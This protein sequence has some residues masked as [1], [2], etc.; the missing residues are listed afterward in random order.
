MEHDESIMN[1]K[2][3]DNT[4]LQTLTKKSSIKLYFRNNI[5]KTL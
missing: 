2:K 5:S 1:K 4:D 3:E